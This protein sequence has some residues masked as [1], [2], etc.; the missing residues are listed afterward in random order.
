[1]TD[2]AGNLASILD[3][4]GEAA[5]RSGRGPESVRLIG[6]T[7]RVTIERIREAIDCGLTDI[8]ENRVQEAESKL[9]FLERTGVTCH[10]IGH[11]QSNKA[12]KA[13]DLF[14]RIQTIDSTELVERLDRLAATPVGVLIQMKL[15]DETTKAG[16]AGGHLPQLVEKVRATRN[17]RLEGLMGIPPFFEDIEQVRPYFRQLRKRAED[18]S[19]ATVSMGMSHDFEVAIEEGATMVRV[20]TLLFGERDAN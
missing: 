10:L 8:G 4:I 12:R 18:F 16:V 3:R 1:M 6:V 13:L 5:L 7:K 14:S 19:L 9:P 17:L 20:G 15:G 2:L 11:L